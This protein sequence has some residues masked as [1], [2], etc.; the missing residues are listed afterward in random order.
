MN[1]L[2]EYVLHTSWALNNLTV[3]VFIKTLI[4]MSTII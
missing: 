4:T 1:Y 2:D 3:S